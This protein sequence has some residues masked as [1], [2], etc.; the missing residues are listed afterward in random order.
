M[1]MA[2]SI[3]VQQAVGDLFNFAPPSSA[4]AHCVGAD[5]LMSAGIA[6]DFKAR[7]NHVDYLLGQGK[8]PGQVAVLPS[9]MSGRDAPVF[10]LVTKAL[11]TNYS[12]SWENFVSSVQELRRLCDE[13]EVKNLAMPRIGCGRDHLQWNDVFSLLLQVFQPSSTNV[14]V[15]NFQ[16]QFNVIFPAVPSPEPSYR[17]FQLLGDSNLVRF[18]VR[19]GA[20]HQSPRD[21]YPKQLGLCV[22]GQSACGLL[23]QLKKEDHLLPNVICMVGTNDVLSLLHL[24]QYKKQAT[25][26]VRGSMLNLIKHLSSRCNQ[27]LFVTIPPIPAHPNSSMYTDRLNRFIAGSGAQPNVR[28]INM[29]D[30]FLSQDGQI[31]TNLFEAVMGP[32]GNQRQDL[33]HL[34]FQG[35]VLLRECLDD[36]IDTP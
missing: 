14:I 36:A 13:M 20:Y 17:G 10:Y 35:Q 9:S 18:A 16:P 4:L 25:F 30:K 31:N 15:F 2:R 21:K 26:G 29:A 24:Q 32:P 34:N 22:S 11:S 5:M 28:V 8:L 7:F 1:P 6:V 12:P 3:R 23:L 19:Y 27:V 33:I